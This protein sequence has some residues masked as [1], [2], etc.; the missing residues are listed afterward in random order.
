MKKTKIRLV[1][2]DL[3]KSGPFEDGGCHDHPKISCKKNYLAKI[4]GSFYAGKFNRQWFGLNFDGWIGGSLQ[5]DTPGT[6]SSDWQQL[7]EIVAL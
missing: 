2:I 1:E 5:Y 4:G 6:N 7:W 3:S